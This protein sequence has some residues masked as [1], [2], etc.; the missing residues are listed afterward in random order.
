MARYDTSTA[1][2]IEL[3]ASQVFAGGT[4]KTTLRP[5]IAFV[6]TSTQNPKIGRFFLLWQD[7][8]TKI[9]NGG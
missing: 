7:G 6:P 4:L 3:P 9:I 8:A 5:G 1:K 2:W